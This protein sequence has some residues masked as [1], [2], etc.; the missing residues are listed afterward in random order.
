MMKNKIF[1]L[2]LTAIL[3]MTG[4]A[5][6]GGENSTE[7]N[8]SVQAAETNADVTAEE[9]L[10]DI[11]SDLLD[12]KLLKG[13][14]KFDKNAAKFYGSDLENIEDGGMLY[15]TEG[16]NADEV[17]VVRFKEGTDGG[18]LL[19]KRLEDRTAT[20]K[21]YRPEEVSKL[22]DAVIFSAGGYDVLIISEDHVEIEKKLRDKLGWPER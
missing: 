22:E 8:D 2:T 1:I 4:C 6:G 15:N 7:N 14:E 19:E 11:S 13:D 9:L 16:Y 12:G 18:A 21:D 20:F 17:S 10:G 3:L 5:S